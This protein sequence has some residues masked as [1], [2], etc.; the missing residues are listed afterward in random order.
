MPP[1]DDRYEHVPTVLVVE[2]HA[3][4]RKALCRLL[5]RAGVG[6]VLE[7]EDGDTALTLL[8]DQTLA[9]SW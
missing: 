1:H 5:H 4:Q 7:A 3:F 9:Q 6:Q 8:R 2:D